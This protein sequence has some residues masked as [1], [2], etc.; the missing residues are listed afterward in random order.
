MN[1]YPFEA[2]R[3]LVRGTS[4]VTV[5]ELR[6]ADISMC[7]S[8]LMSVSPPV[9]EDQNKLIPAR[10]WFCTRRVFVAFGVAA[11][12]YVGLFALNSFSGGYWNKLERD[13]HD[14]WSFGLSMHTATLW[15]PR[16][17]YWALYR[18]DWLGAFY[19]P[20]IRLD[21]RFIHHTH[22]VSDPEFSDWA[23]TLTVAD[24]HP[25]FQREVAAVLAHRNQ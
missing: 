19:S 12:F 25:R 20:L 23:K 15:Q 1:A 3:L 21:R 18:S 24:W 7:V 10:K 6:L 8:S 11:F 5:G 4:D 14:R 17:G 22:Y 16:Y 13:G 2:D 9:N